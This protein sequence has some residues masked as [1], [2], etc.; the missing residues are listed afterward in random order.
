MT[1]APNAE[2][3]RESIRT[4]KPGRCITHDE[5]AW[6]YRD[7]SIACFYAQIVETSTLDCVWAESSDILA[8]R[9]LVETVT[10][11]VDPLMRSA[12]LVDALVAGVSV[13]S[14]DAEEQ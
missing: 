11:E 1:D 4:R 7:G 2:R 12:R 10:D 3:A 9:E 13:L 5:F 8:L 6:R 14:Q